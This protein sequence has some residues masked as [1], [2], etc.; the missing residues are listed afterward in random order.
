[1]YTKFDEIKATLGIFEKYLKRV[2]D[3]Y[4]E[5]YAEIRN[6]VNSNMK[7]DDVEKMSVYHVTSE[8]LVEDGN[9]YRLCE[10]VIR[11]V[12]EIVSLYDYNQNVLESGIAEENA[13]KANELYK[14]LKNDVNFKHLLSDFAIK[15]INE[16]DK[17]LDGIDGDYD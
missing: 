3:E 15:L 1:M 5:H 12:K 16:G 7:P 8:L 11:K 2:K 13:S 4:D 17:Y 9:E 10:D 6:Y 14:D